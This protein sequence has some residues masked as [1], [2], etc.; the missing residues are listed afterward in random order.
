VRKVFPR[1]S[2]FCQSMPRRQAGSLV[3]CARWCATH[4]QHFPWRGQSF[5]QGQ[6]MWLCGQGMVL[7]LTCTIVQRFNFFLI[8]TSNLLWRAIFLVVFI[9]RIYKCNLR[10]KLVW[11]LWLILWKIYLFNSIEIPFLLYYSPLYFMTI[12]GE[13]RGYIPWISRESPA[14]T[15]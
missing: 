3:P 5:G 14:M 11:F 8:Y 1:F 2:Y 12:I 4:S 6:S 7:F 9:N 15:E 13:Q 10:D